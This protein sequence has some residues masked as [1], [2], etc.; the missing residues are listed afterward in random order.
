MLIRKIEPLDGLPRIRINCKPVYEYADSN[1]LSTVRGSNHIDYQ[2]GPDK[3][4]L[5]T[6]IPVSYLIEGQFYS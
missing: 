6:N 4:R 1:C 3:I 5:T 2:G